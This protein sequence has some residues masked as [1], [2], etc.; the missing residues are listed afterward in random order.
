MPKAKHSTIKNGFRV[1]ARQ[2]KRLSRGQAWPRNSLAQRQQKSRASAFKLKPK[3]LF[4][5]EASQIATVVEVDCLDRPGLLYDVTQAIFELGLSISTA[6]VATYGERAIDAFMSETVWPQG[7][8]PGP[9]GSGTT[10]ARQST[11]RP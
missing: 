2:L 10:A 11:G 4:D 6:M 5:N 8:P 1:Y 3:V 7:Y 9:A